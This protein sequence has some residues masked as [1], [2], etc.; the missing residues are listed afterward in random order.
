MMPNAARMQD[1]IET[2]KAVQDNAT[3]GAGTFDVHPDAARKYPESA[4]RRPVEVLSGFHLVADEF[5][6][7]I[8]VSPDLTV[9]EC[10][11]LAHPDGIRS[12]EM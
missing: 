12:I 9:Q 2:A 7:V 5:L 8:L 4:F 11:D 10:L 3:M 6:K 1:I